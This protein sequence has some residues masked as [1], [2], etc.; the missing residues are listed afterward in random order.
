MYCA[1]KLLSRSW[2]AYVLSGNLLEEKMGPQGSLR[3][4]LYCKIG[5][6]NF[7]KM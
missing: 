3:R 6:H 5:M 2:H 1:N 7:P 4:I